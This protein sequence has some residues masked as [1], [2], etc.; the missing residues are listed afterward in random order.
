MPAFGAALQDAQIWDIVNYVMS[1]PYQKGPSYTD[2]QQ[3]HIAAS[4]LQELNAG[5][6]HAAE[7][8]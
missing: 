2:Q 4:S 6:P 3:Q 1:L 5:Q 8:K 7:D